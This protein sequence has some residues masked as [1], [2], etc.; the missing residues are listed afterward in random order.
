MFNYLGRWMLFVILFGLLPVQINASE[1]A[2]GSIRGI[3]KQAEDIVSVKAVNRQ[4]GKQFVGIVDVKAQKI[5]VPALPIEA[6]YDVLI[7]TKEQLLEGINLTVPRSEYEEE[8]SLAEE[9]VKTIRE[10]VLGLN[11]FEDVVEILTIEGNIQHAAILLNKVRTKPFVNSLPG[12][13][14]W[15][16]E[17]WHFQR[18]EETWLKATEEL[19]IVLHRERLQGD[20]FEKK[21]VTFDPALG[22]I[23]LTED[24]PKRDLGRIELPAVKPGVRLRMKEKPAKEKE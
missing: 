2:I 4:S 5:T 9:D 1:K 19:F 24:E 13:V 8:Q 6:A 15:R 17:L 18:P 21:S 23:T 14:V 11:Q 16:A 22:G 7:E 10:K 12:E 3:V 20:A